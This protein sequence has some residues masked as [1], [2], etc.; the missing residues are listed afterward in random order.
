MKDNRLL[1][2]LK[3]YWVIPAVI[4]IVLAAVFSSVEIYKEEVLNI[5]PDVKYQKQKTLYF[6]A[7]SIDTLNPLISQSEDT[8]Y[9]SKLIYNSLF[10]YDE[11]LSAVPELVDS[12]KVNTDRAYIEMTLKKGIK[13]H[14]GK[15]LKADDVRF[16]VNAIKAAGS[17]SPYY[18]KASKIVAVNVTGTYQCSI[19]FNNNYNCSL[20]DLTFPIVP[21]SQYG[22]AYQFA[23]AKDGF[24]PVGTGMYQYRSYNYLKYLRLNPNEDYFDKEQRAKNK[25]YVNII[26]KRSLA[27]NL[28][29]I[30]TVT[31]YLDDSSSRRSIV[32]DKN[33]QMYDV[34][35]NQVE[36][37]VYNTKSKVLKD[38]DVR[39][40]VSYGIDREKILA[41]A[42]MGDGVLSDTIYYPNYLGV[43]DEGTA[44]AYDYQKAQQMLL[45][46]GLTDRN[47]DG[48]LEDMNGDAV[49]LRIVVNKKNATRTAAARLIEKN[50]E[51]IGIRSE[52][53]ALTTK[54]YQA[55]IRARDFD[56]LLTGYRMEESY[57][58]RSFFD[59]TNPWGYIDYDL[60]ASVRELSRL[61]TETEYR[62]AFAALKT[63]MLDEMPYYPLC[64]RYTGL[65]GVTTFKAEALPMFNDIYK[66]CNTWSWSKIVQPDTTEED[67]AAAQESE[68]N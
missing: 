21:S 4:L 64:Y 26:P 39:Q 8:Y 68:Q 24:K 57:D 10:E 48:T 1:L 51:T 6:A 41:N 60:L 46:A 14:N 45:S 13:W 62:E 32:S 34:L 53:R 67:P 49:T 2:F 44:Y 27:E 12:Y 22:N 17:T 55:A 40:A 47:G 42:Y 63:Q 59:R 58:L 19:Y 35:S 33:Y 3:K 38:K 9:L 28:M 54:E 31:C 29:E 37:I 66:N 16:T 65:I 30:D 50:L 5:D 7:E 56:I 52:V 23:K 61:H 36:M 25:I 43:A 15:T 20:D 18:A 11:N